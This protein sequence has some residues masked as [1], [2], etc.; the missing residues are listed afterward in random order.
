[1]QGRQEKCNRDA[2]ANAEVFESVAF[3]LFCFDSFIRETGDFRQ[4]IGVS[5]VVR[6]GI[7]FNKVF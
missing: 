2:T 1:L 3:K 6:I 7:A 4:G 5:E